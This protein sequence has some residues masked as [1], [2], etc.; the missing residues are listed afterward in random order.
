ATV[1]GWRNAVGQDCAVPGGVGLCGL[2]LSGAAGWLTCALAAGRAA[3]NERRMRTDVKRRAQAEKVSVWQEPPADP[4]PVALLNHSEGPV[5][6]AVATF[7]FVDG[8]GPARGEESAS[9]RV[10]WRG[11]GGRGPPRPGGVGLHG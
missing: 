4:Q 1:H 10:G 2:V 8:T 5:Y 7:V 11:Q 9:G 3:R 6:D